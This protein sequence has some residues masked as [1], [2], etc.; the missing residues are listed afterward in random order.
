MGLTTYTPTRLRA[1]VDE[2]SIE[3]LGGANID[4]A[5]V[6]A[7]SE[8]KKTILAGTVMSAK[9][10]GQLQ[11]RSYTVT[12]SA[13]AVASNVATATLT[14]HGFSVG[15]TV[16]ISGAGTSYVNGLKTIASVPNANSFTFTATGAD[17]GSVSGTI[18]VSRT[19]TC[20]LETNARQ[21]S[22]AIGYNGYSQI[23]GGVLYENLLP[24]A[25]GTP[26]KLPA[27]YKTELA[28]AGCTFKFTS[29]ADSR[30]S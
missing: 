13:V 26:K 28:S 8:G 15:E 30:A 7:D 6:T 25:T 29:Y 12:P 9:A 14:A 21:D 19:A 11:P 2:T 17:V 18:L 27:Q 1:V 4:W 22:A 10:N 24:D 16:Y 3:R 5:S 20:I 23:A